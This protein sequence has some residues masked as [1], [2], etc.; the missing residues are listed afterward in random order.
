VIDIRDSREQIPYVTEQGNKSGEQG[1]KL[2]DQGIKSLE[3]GKRSADDVGIPISG[4]L[5]GISHP[6]N[7]TSYVF[8]P[9]TSHSLEPIEFL[10]AHRHHRHSGMEQGLCSTGERIGPPLFSA[11]GV[12]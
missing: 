6:H 9:R 1:D 8:A 3:Q 2:G 10:L 12:G 4:R 11:S 7:R 5:A